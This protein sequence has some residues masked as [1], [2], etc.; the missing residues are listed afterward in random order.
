MTSLKEMI[1][2]YSR[3]AVRLAEYKRRLA[4]QIKAERDVD[5]L[6][7][8]E[9]RKSTVEAERYE[10]LDDLRS[11]IRYETERGKCRKDA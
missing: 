6:K 3:E 1:A 10:I 5:T 8:L 4:E 9:L 2:S 11:M 7:E